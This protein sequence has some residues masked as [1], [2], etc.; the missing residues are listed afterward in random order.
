V[1]GLAERMGARV[2]ARNVAE[3]GFEVAV[4]LSAAGG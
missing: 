1:R 4:L 2:A 3:G